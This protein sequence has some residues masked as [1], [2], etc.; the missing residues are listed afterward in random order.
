MINTS[1]NLIT[2]CNNNIKKLKLLE[3]ILLG[4]GISYL[5]III[6]NNQPRINK[7]KQ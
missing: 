2:W 6:T 7:K 1:T 5:F 3:I 4:L